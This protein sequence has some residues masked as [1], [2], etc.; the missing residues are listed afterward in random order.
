[1]QSPAGRLLFAQSVSFIITD[2]IRAG[3][4]VPDSIHNM[5][6][7][8]MDSMGPQ[9]HLILKWQTLPA[10]L[11]I[12]GLKSAIIHRR[13]ADPRIIIEEAREIDHMF[14]TAY[15]EVPYSFE[16]RVVAHRTKYGSSLPAYVYRYHNSLSSSAWNGKYNDSSSFL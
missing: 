5:L 14:A 12:A 15:T 10:Y 11:R 4:P 13:I 6:T 3:L 7:P 8:F 9:D 1:M 2:C 16:Y